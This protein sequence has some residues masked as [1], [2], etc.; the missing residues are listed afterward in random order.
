MMCLAQ[1]DLAGRAATS[2][3]AA[4][5]TSSPPPWWPIIAKYWDLYWLLDDDQQQ[6]LL[7]L[8]PDGV[9]RRPGHVGHRR[10]RRPY[11][12]RGDRT[13]ARAYADSAPAA[14]RGADSGDARTTRSCHVLLGIALAYLGRKDEA[15][16]GGGAGVRWLPI[17]QGRLQRAVQPAPARADLHPGRASRTRRSTSSSRCSRFPTISRPAWLRIDPTFD[18]LR[19]EPALPEAGGGNAVSPRFARSC[20]AAPGRPLHARPRARPR[21]HGD[22]LPRA[23]PQARAPGRAQGAPPGAGRSRSA[24]SGSCARSSSPPGCSTRTS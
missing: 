17:T 21:R 13:R 4:P 14:L 11:A 12:L 9:R 18:P 8:T 2:S 22:G 10:W 3:G 23:G 16:R 6:L 20:E 24:P 5:R 7:R 15:M 1:G 19:S